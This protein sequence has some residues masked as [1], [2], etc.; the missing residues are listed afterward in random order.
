MNEFFLHYVWQFQYFDKTD[1]R[2]TTGDPV[3]IF[4][5]GNRN[6]DGGPDFT[7][8]RLRIGSIQWVGNVEIH[9]DSSAWYQHAHEKDPAYDNVILHVVWNDDS[10]VRRSDGNLLPTLELQSR[11]DPALLEQYNYLMGSISIIPC[12]AMLHHV[13]PIVILNTLDKMLLSRLEA[14]AA[15]VLTVLDRNR[16]D[17]HET[18]YQLLAKNFGFKINADPFL[19]L[20]QAIPLKVLRKHGDKLLQ[21]EAM[22]FGVAGFLNEDCDD[23]YYLLLRREYLLLRSKFKLDEKAMKTMQWKFLRLRPANFPT[24]RLAQF[25]ALLAREQNI[26]DTFLSADARKLA[27]LFQQPPSEYWQHHYNFRRETARKD[28]VI[29]TDASHNLMINTVAPVLAA[30]SMYSD[31]QTYMDHAIRLLQHLPAESN[32]IIS[33]WNAVSLKCK[34]AFDSQAL[35]ELYTNLCSR[36]RCLD[37]NIGASLIKPGRNLC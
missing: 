16:G 14:K 7:H 31:D 26:F 17:W 25:A 37:C 27:L 20:A 13:R 32:R 3:Q 12:S 33:K 35:I 1:L 9:I 19:Q 15:T 24:L 4:S 21:L 23:S 2:T 28:A 22:L 29:G 18:T 10:P 34:S 5:V 30:Y 11:V 6:P 8:A 36:Y